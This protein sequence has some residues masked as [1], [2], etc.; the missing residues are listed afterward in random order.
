MTA[1]PERLTFAEDGPVYGHAIVESTTDPAR[2]RY[3]LSDVPEFVRINH[4]DRKPFRCSSGYTSGRPRNAERDM[5]QVFVR[6][7]DSGST[8]VYR[9]LNAASVACGFTLNNR[10]VAILRD[11]GFFEASK[12]TIWMDGAQL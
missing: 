1:S 4:P 2:S 3:W 8:A 9:S 10:S 7:K 12:F 5:R 6:D 11:K